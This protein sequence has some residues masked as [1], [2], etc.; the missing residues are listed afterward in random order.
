[1]R[2]GGLTKLVSRLSVR[3]V[4]R[5]LDPSDS[6]TSV[7]KAS[8]RTRLG[9]VYSCSR[10]ARKGREAGHHQPSACGRAQSAGAAMRPSLR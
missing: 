10:C 3:M 6:S 4:S 2:N 5:P 9:V 7:R 1:M 8:H